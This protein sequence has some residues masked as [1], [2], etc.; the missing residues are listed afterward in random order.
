MSNRSYDLFLKK[1]GLSF[2][3]ALNFLDIKLKEYQPENKDEVVD[4]EFIDKLAVKAKE[5]KNK[6]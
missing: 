2:D 3:E 1:S 4:L 5:W 6:C